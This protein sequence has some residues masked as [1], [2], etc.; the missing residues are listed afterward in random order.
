LNSPS[1]SHMCPACLNDTTH[2]LWKDSFGSKEYYFIEC[3][4]C[5]LHF[6]RP[7]PDAQALSLLYDSDYPC[8]QALTN[9][10]EQKY[11]PLKAQ[12][13]RWRFARMQGSFFKFLLKK[14]LSVCVEIALGRYVSFP[15]GVPLSLPCDAKIIDVGCGSGLWLIFMKQQ[16]YTNLMGVD[17]GGPAKKRLEPLGIPVA[18]GALPELG[19][20]EAS[21]DLIRME[22]VPNPAEYLNEIARLLKPN[23]CLVIVVPA[24]ESLSYKVSRRNWAHLDFPRHLYHYSLKSLRFLGSRSGLVVRR[25][26]YLP[27]WPVMAASVACLI[28]HCFG[29]NVQCFRSRIASIILSP[30]WAIFMSIFQTG[31]VLTVEF[32]RQAAIKG[33]K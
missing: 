3:S 24:I 10:I 13:A 31:D 32:V 27:V 17:I 2:I 25:Y 12:I 11:P 28:E 30:L 16:G 14:F 19:L 23:G 33:D 7:I 4:S 6:V 9:E 15:L 1:Y 20:P 29:R 21:F 26:R 22:H 8:Y 5:K 18:V